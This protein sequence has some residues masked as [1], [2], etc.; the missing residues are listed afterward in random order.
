MTDPTTPDP[1]AKARELLADIEREVP[2][3]GGLYIAGIR[4]HD[5]LASLC[6]TVIAQAE[7]LEEWA[8]ARRAVSSAAPADVR[9]NPE[10]GPMLDRLATA[11]QSLVNLTTIQEARHG[12]R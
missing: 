9:T 6:R 3:R 1:V 4:R 11:E 10:F 8:A 2:S 5:D 7:A 12:T